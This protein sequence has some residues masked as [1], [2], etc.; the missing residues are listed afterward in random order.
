MELKNLLTRRF[1]VEKH[2]KQLI[3]SLTFPFRFLTG[4]LMQL[5]VPDFMEELGEV[6]LTMRRVIEC[7]AD[8]RGNDEG[9][10]EALLAQIARLSARDQKLLDIYSLLQGFYS[11]DILW[12][13]TGQE[14][15]ER[16]GFV[17]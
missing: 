4:F 14:V 10:K 2:L 13:A 5:M 6:P 7:A 9:F 3:D 16:R 1:T 11:M 15:A 8:E 17:E 12:L